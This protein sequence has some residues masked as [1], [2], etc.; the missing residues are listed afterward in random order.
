M[1]KLLLYTKLAELYD[2]IYNKIFDYERS[3][4]RLNKILK[5]YKCKKIL[6]VASGNGRL[7]KNLQS[8]L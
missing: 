1:S 8:W 2:E 6:E 4:G 3:A 7:A 5:K